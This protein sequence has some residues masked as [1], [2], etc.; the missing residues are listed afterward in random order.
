M[1]AAR[2]LQGLLLLSYAAALSGCGDASTAPAPPATA[3]ARFAPSLDTTMDWG[4]VPFPNDLYR[5][6]TG[7]IR[8]RGSM[9]IHGAWL[10]VRERPR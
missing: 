1:R 10:L 6:A 7:T 2:L 8:N 4:D 9:R 3:V 5:D